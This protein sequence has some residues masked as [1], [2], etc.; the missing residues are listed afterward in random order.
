M[1][2][3][4]NN[5]GGVGMEKIKLGGLEIN[6]KLD[7]ITAEELRNAINYLFSDMDNMVKKA[8]NENNK[9]IPKKQ[10]DTNN[11]EITDKQLKYIN[12]L[13]K[14][15]ELTKAELQ[16]YSIS[17]FGKNSSLELTRNE[18]SQLIAT[19]NDIEDNVLDHVKV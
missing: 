13:A 5:Y 2:R 9:D 4:N 11:S 19:L 17:M 16:N 7:N 3:N 12:S 6:I 18:A 14:E 8:Q 15:K 1:L 10:I